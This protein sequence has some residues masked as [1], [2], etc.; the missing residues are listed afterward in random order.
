M[1]TQLSAQEIERR[2]KQSL[3]AK[4]MNR[5]SVPTMPVSNVGKTVAEK[6]AEGD[7]STANIGSYTNTGVNGYQN[8]GIPKMSQTAID[9]QKKNEEAYNKMAPSAEQF[10]ANNAKASTV[11]EAAASGVTDPKVI[12][13]FG[14]QTKPPLEFGSNVATPNVTAPTPTT[15]TTPTQTGVTPPSASTAPTTPTAPTTGAT[16]TP[17]ATAGQTASTGGLPTTAGGANVTETTSP[18][19]G[20]TTSPS[21]GV[22]EY[23]QMIQNAQDTLKTGSEFAVM[24]QQET[25]EN[26]RRKFLSAIGE[27]TLDE[28]AMGQNVNLNAMTFQELQNYAMEQGFDV[29][30]NFKKQIQA[31]G[32]SAIEDM[33]FQ[34]NQELAINDLTARQIERKRERALDEREKHNMMQDVRNRALMGSFGVQDIASN[35]AVL[36]ALDEGVRAKEELI[37]DFA[38]RLTPIAMNAQSLI[39]A[40]NTNVAQVEAQGAQ[41]IE[42]KYAE[43]VAKLQEYADQGV[44]SKKELRKAMLTEIKDYGKLIGDINA[45]KLTYIQEENKQF[46]EQ[47]K[48]LREQQFKEDETYMQQFGVLFKNG[49]PLL[50]SAGNEVPTLENMK[51]SNEIDQALTLNTGYVYQNKQPLLDKNGNQ[52]ATFSLNKFNAEEERA[53]KTFDENVRQFGLTYAQAQEKQRIEMAD[54][55]IVAVQQNMVDPSSGINPEKSQYGM[56]V[57]AD[58]A[59]AFNIPA[60]GKAPNGRGQCGEFVNDA[61]GLTGGKKFTNSIEEKEALR[62]SLVPVAGGAFIQRTGNQYGHV[63]I[64]EKINSFDAQGRPTSINIIDSNYVGN[65]KIAQSRVDIEYDGSG[66]PTYYRIGQN[67]KR[68]KIDITGF[69]T[70]VQSGVSY[71]KDTAT[72]SQSILDKIPKNAVSAVTQISGRFDNE[73][74]VKN[75][76]MVQGAKDLV[77]SLPN[78]TKNPTDDQALIYAFAKV[79]DPGSVVREGEYNTVQRYSQSWAQQYGSSVSNALLGTG[80]LTPE[81]RKNI[82]KTID[83]KYNVEK[84]SYDSLRRSYINNIDKVAG[85][86][87][88]GDML[89]EYTVSYTQDDVPAGY[90]LMR[91]ENDQPVS[92]PEG[93]INEYMDFGYTSY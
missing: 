81:A 50:D 8:T 45:K 42:D 43:I 78:D 1:A 90:V 15:P 34:L 47:T 20:E 69:T 54:K 77:N 30:E 67:G 40:Y 79:M 58:G 24:D 92:V 59:V 89:P 85:T 66:K 33:K 87:V 5:A 56:S 55:G 38:D 31:Q 7:R 61:L 68:S 6:Y 86:K 75:F 21:T 93:Q 65:E 62:N 64:T 13:S 57:T 9:A 83:T 72:S 91:D 35:G 19:T 70:G 14:A 36:Q 11:G 37:L 63:G 27:T 71:Q 18:T 17:T 80:F 3:E 49:I 88:G 12:G 44:T 52:I 22:A 16:A 25:E 60:D 2:R 28:T 39:R 29:D 26:L 23:D 74:Q 82:K 41:I 4:K 32:A 51:F 46:F 10:A 53:K 48:F 76:Q 84:G 73:P